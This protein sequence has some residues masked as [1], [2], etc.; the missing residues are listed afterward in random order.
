MDY[1]CHTS[2]VLLVTFSLEDFS[3]WEH[4]KRLLVT[5][6]DKRVPAILVGT[7]ADLKSDQ[8][9]TA[10]EALS[11]ANEMR[12]HYL[13]TSAASG[14]NVEQIFQLAVN[15]VMEK[16]CQS[17]LLQSLKLEKKEHNLQPFRGVLR[18]WN[19]IRHRKTEPFLSDI[20]S[21]QILINT[22]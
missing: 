8:A 19:S 13:E 4:A 15:L 9:V 12:C 18:R 3:S 10:E 21:N 22:L 5:A 7:K 17:Q 6:S 20:S 11:V 14:M 2:D 16:I 1:Y